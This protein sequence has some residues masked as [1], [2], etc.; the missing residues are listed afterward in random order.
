[1]GN[2]L[3]IVNLQ[4][5]KSVR[6]ISA[7]HDY[8]FITVLWISS[9]L[10]LIVCIVIFVINKAREESDESLRINR[11]MLASIIE[12]SSSLIY[13]FD[14]KGKCLLANHA[15]S[16]V[17]GLSPDEIIG[18]TRYQIMPRE[19]AIE[20]DENDLS[21]IESRSQYVFEE[22]S[23]D[24]ENLRTYLTVKFP[25]T[26]EHD[27]VYAVGGISTDITERINSEFKIKKSL[28][29]KEILLREL[30][31]RTKNNMQVIHSMLRLQS[32]QSKNDEVKNVLLEAGN[33]I[34]S[35]ALVHQKLYQA[36]N[37]SFIY[38]N[39]Y[40]TELTGLISKSYSIRDENF[41]FNIQI[42]EIRISIDAAIPL[43]LVVSELLSNSFKYAF[44]DK[45]QA[46]ISINAKLSDESIISMIFSDNGVGVPEGFDFR[47][48]DSLGLKIVFAVV[49]SQL[50]GNIDIYND[51]GVKC[52]IAFNNSFYSK[53]RV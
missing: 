6:N 22:K 41:N 43:G 46:L 36:K 33:K 38:L 3:D 48:Q 15:A 31:H 16:S 17:F 27:R 28:E 12:N 34:M 52:Q 18:K 2:K 26:D 51:N 30:Y 45:R 29:E 13:L 49:E 35:M 14:N 47:N 7:K 23:S 42:D 10:L 25:L 40:L 53:T 21:V 39:E 24:G 9:F 8:E 50:Q 44:P 32:A 11:N 19:S 20:H 5:S 37:L 1:M 4:L